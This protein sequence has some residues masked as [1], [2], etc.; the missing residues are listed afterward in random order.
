[1]FQNDTSPNDSKDSYAMDNQVNYDELE[2]LGIEAVPFNKRIEAFYEGTRAATDLSEQVVIPQL[3]ALIK[4]SQ[5]ERI[6]VGLYYRMFLWMRSLASLNN[7]IH[8]QAAASATRSIFELLLDIK[9]LIN[10]KPKGSVDKFETFIQVE[11]FRV[12]KKYVDFKNKNPGLKY[13]SGFTKEKLVNKPGEES[14]IDKLIE[15]KW[16]KNS[17]GEPK[18]V[19]HW[20]CWKIDKRAEE[21]GKDC[22]YFYR[23]SFALL[24]WYTHSGLVGVKGVSKEGFDA[25]FGNAHMLAQPIFLDATLLVAREL[26]LIQAIPQLINWAE[27]AKLIVGNVIIKEQ[28]KYL[29]NL[30][31]KESTGPSYK[32]TP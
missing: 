8:F 27:E 29:K 26:K 23:E 11:R 2:K 16:G 7:T 19:E 9:L 22:E 20:T 12:A 30:Q 15:L 28:I 10:D 5:K 6:I 14:R 1:M 21:A 24:S 13:K 32:G 4:P 25:I 17:K 3:A 31:D 18:K